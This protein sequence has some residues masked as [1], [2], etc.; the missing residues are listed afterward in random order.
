MDTNFTSRLMVV[1]EHWNLSY[2]EF[3]AHI[4]FVLYSSMLGG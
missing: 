2:T 4:Q 1:F 3:F